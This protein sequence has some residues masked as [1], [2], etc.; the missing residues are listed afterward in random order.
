MTKTEYARLVEAVNEHRH[1][2]YVLDTPTISDDDYDALERRLREIEAKHPDW[3][4]A[5]SPTQTVGGQRSE[6]FEPVTHLERMY[7]LDNAFS[8]EELQAWSARIVKDLGALPPDAVRAEGR[9]PCRGPRVP[10]RR[11]AL[12]RHP[13]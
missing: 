10:R 13:R 6:M 7:S 5:D 2:Y 1:R 9:W 8:T 11:A 4:S 3:V 12:G